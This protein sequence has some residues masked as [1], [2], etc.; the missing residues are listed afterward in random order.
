MSS[1]AVLAR[2]PHLIP[3]LIIPLAAH[4]GYALFLRLK[5][6][7]LYK[8]PTVWGPLSVVLGGWL[9]SLFNIYYEPRTLMRG[10]NK[11]R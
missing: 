6:P 3:F 4:I 7:D 9:E 8:I 5:N 11:V 2:V 1:E 10:Y